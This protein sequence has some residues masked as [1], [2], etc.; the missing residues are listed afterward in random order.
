M[1]NHSRM[2]VRKRRKH[3]PAARLG[4][5]GSIPVVRGSRLYK[6]TAG[7]RMVAQGPITKIAA[8]GSTF[9]GSWVIIRLLKRLMAV[10]G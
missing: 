9:Q 7:D 2:G 5:A 10:G 6:S 3:N 4:S 8:T 1:Y